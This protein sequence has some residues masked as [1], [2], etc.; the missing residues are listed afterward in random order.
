MR[1]K[2]INP[3]IRVVTPKMKLYMATYS[4]KEFKRSGNK[5]N[6]MTVGDVNEE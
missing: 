5:D 1:K 3:F 6:V 2:Y 4:V